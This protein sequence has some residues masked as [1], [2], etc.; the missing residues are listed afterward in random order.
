MRGDGLGLATVS[1][2]REQADEEERALHRRAAC[3]S[4]AV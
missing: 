2:W 3:A 1:L 4:I